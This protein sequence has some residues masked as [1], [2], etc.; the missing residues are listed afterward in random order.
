MGQTVG[1]ASPAA[2]V[3]GLTG[4]AISDVGVD[5]S[6]EASLA[7]FA[8]GLRISVFHSLS[9]TPSTGVCMAGILIAGLTVASF[10]ILSKTPSTGVPPAS[11]SVL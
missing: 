6:L 11:Q 1:A 5:F 10:Q 4:L 7:F 3:I 8:A 9:M 2:A